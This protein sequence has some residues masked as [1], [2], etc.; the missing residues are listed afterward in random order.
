MI[1]H[2]HTLRNQEVGGLLILKVKVRLEKAAKDTFYVW[3][4]GE[5]GVVSISGL[6]VWAHQ[7]MHSVRRT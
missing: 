6:A 4:V 2:A 7:N 1:P 3:C 5:Q